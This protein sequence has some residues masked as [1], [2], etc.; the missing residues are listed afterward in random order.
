MLR[1]VSKSCSRRLLVLL[2]WCLPLLLTISSADAQ[3]IPIGSHEVGRATDGG[4]GSG[5]VSPTGGISASI[6]LALP[7]PR[8]QLPVPLA[9]VYDG[10]SRVGE[11][12][13]GWSIPTSFVSVSSSLARRRPKFDPAA[14]WTDAVADPRAEVWLSLGGPV[15]RMVRTGGDDYRPMVD[16][17][18]L[19][20]SRNEGDWVLEDGSGRTYRFERVASLQN[21][22]LWLLTEITDRTGRNTIILTYRVEIVAAGAGRGLKELYLNGLRYD[23]R[24]GPISSTNPTSN[25]RRD[26]L[27][28]KHQ[29]KLHYENPFAESEVL[30]YT[31]QSSN[32]LVRTK[33]LQRVE[34]VAVSEGPKDIPALDAA[35]C[36]SNAVRIREYRFTYKHDPDTQLPR[37]AAVDVSGRIGTPEGNRHV[38]VAR[39]AYGAATSKRRSRDGDRIL[40]YKS[41]GI[42]PLPTEAGGALGTLYLPT[43]TIP[44]RASNPG[45]H[46]RRAARS[47]LA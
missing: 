26:L 32:V 36:D 11:A 28:A 47:T 16:H 25:T 19:L 7:A 1:K 2:A 38:P 5:S 3:Q 9:V 45:L 20:L 22:P 21:E 4:F 34:V 33:V 40:E 37:L 46:G 24:P 41:T 13:V 29:I 31:A 8:G 23:F 17:Q 12:G 27:C 18:D 39:F 42:V 6:P 35:S 14:E 30:G 44:H 10:G 43:A 15:L